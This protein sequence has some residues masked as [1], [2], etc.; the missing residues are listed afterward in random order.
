MAF[1]PDNFWHNAD[2]K[3][4][5]AKSNR[6]IVDIRVPNGLG[7]DIRSLQLQ[8]ETVDLP[9][10]VLAT[11][12]VKVYGPAY[13]MAIHKQYANEINLNFLCTNQGHERKIFDD[14]IEYITPDDTNNLK[15]PGGIDGSAGAYLTDVFITQF[16]E[17][18]SGKTIPT[19][20]TTRSLGVKSEGYRIEYGGASSDQI[21]NRVVL[22]NCFPVSYAPQPLNW[23]DDGIQ[24]LSVQFSYRSFIQTI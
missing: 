17:T 20:Q 8:C 1:S 18:W 7:V 5:F 10:K 24:R 11:Q 12:D 3:L 23:G 13:K 21:I 2:K 6:F 22:K 16:N 19:E 14:W 9:G 15:F 4:G